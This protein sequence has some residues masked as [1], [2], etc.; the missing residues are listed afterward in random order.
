MDIEKIDRYINEKGKKAP[1]MPIHK[2]LEKAKDEALSALNVVKAELGGGMD[3]RKKVRTIELM[4]P[5]I[6]AL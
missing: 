4:I 6:K 1:Q 2:N 5:K 3:N